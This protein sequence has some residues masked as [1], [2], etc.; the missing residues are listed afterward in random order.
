MGESADLK[1]AF[2]SD[3]PT[4]RLLMQR[5]GKLEGGVL[6]VSV[7]KQSEKANVTKVSID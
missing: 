3:D 6:T 5:A 2:E 4:V 7:P 1:A